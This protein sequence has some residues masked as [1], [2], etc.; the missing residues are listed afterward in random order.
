M[1]GLMNS[2][3]RF[4]SEGVGVLA[5]GL[6]YSAFNLIPLIGPFAAG[7]AAS[8]FFCGGVGR[9]F[10]LGILGGFLGATIF[11]LALI[12]LEFLNLSAGALPAFILG[13]ILLVWNA[14]G[15]LACGLGAAAGVMARD[16]GRFYGSFFRRQGQPEDCVVYRICP[17]CNE[18]TPE[19]AGFCVKCGSVM[20]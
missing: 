16:V 14:F 18:G 1:M 19:K 9:A 17:V 4:F 6:I 15:L 11:L 8:V 2:L 12:K 20:A 3:G 5:G 10:K 13:W 7:F